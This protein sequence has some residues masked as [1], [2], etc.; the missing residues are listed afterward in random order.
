MDLINL[1]LYN[2][3]NISSLLYLHKNEI[4]TKY[5]NKQEFFHNILLAEILTLWH[6]FF[7]LFSFNKKKLVF[8]LILIVYTYLNKICFERK[9][10]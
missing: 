5:V 2:N 3:S 9:S 6:F 4:N 10:S 8:M 1:Y 7:I